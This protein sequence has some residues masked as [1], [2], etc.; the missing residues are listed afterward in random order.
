[1]R[2]NK[3]GLPAGLCWTVDRHGKRRLRYFGRDFSLYFHAPFGSPEFAAEYA[4]ALARNQA[5][6]VRQPIGVARTIPGSINAL[7]VSYYEMVLPLKGE[8]TQAARRG[9]L[10]KFRSEHGHRSVT[11]AS[12]QL[13]EG[14]I[15]KKAKQAPHGANNLHKA[16]TDLFKHAVR[17][18]LRADNPMLNVMRIKTTGDGHHTWITAELAQYRAH[19]PLGT[20]Q[21]LVFELAMELATRRGEIVKLGPQ[22]ERPATED[23]PYGLL[24]LRRLKGSDDTIVPISAELRAAIDAC[25]PFRHMTY[26]AAKNGAARSAKGLTGDFRAWCTAA[27][28]PKRCRLH[29][30]KKSSLTEFANASASVKEM[31]SV[32]GNKSLAVL[33][34]YIDKADKA[35]LAVQAMAKRSKAR[36]G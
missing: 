13:L 25:A 3:T 14:I 6:P 1:M 7:I 5:L 4:A 23:A 28:L 2:K 16:L 9:I 33:Q 27:G 31:Q 36:A 19:W 10:E 26:L 32:S 15:L 20:Y 30:L 11:G 12:W 22:H 35:R 29:G 17:L 8:G 34:K 21:R 24:D 18:G